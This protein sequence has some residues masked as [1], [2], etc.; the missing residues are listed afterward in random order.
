M[1]K[2]YCDLCGNKIEKLYTYSL[3]VAATFVGAEPYDLIDMQF[4]LCKDCRIKLY[5]VIK[6]NISEDSL[7]SLN[8]HAL[9]IK[10]GRTNETH[11]WI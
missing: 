2:Y 10:M 1:I 11:V 5:N 9:D 4:D 8:H 7:R 3:P 6:S